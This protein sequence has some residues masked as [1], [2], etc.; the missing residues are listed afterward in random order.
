MYEWAARLGAERGLPLATHL[1]ET[2]EEREF[3]AHGT[4][5]QREMLE[6]LGVWDNAALE[7]VG[8]GNH[9]VQHLAGV[10][11]MAR[12]VAAHVNDA[13]DAAIET[14]A[15]TGTVVAYCP[16][17]SAYFGAERPFGPH[18]YR[19]MMEAGVVVALGTDSIVNLPEA[20][21]MEGIS[22]LDEMRFLHRRDGTDPRL[23]V[24]MGTVNGAGAL[25]I[26]PAMFRIEDGNT[27][28]GLIA[29][30]A[31]PGQGHALERAMRGTERLELLFPE[32]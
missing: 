9:P 32:D 12:F 5:P 23:L 11:G 8:K 4:G 15:R 17:A 30:P 6:R 2:V 18:R 1:A 27:L 7:H 22:V 3:V 28:A 26:D 14:L 19:E 16:R 13:D 21:V 24:R 31:D 25:G 29:I 10:L 20:A